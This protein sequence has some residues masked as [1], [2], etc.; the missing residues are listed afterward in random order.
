MDKDRKTYMVSLEND[1]YDTYIMALTNDRVKV[2]K[3]LKEKGY[4]FTITEQGNVIV[5]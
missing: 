3:W 5:L 4:D 1:V 2:F